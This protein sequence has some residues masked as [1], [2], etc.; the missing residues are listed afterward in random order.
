[1][2]IDS[3]SHRGDLT[4]RGHAASLKENH[5]GATHTHTHTHTYTHTRARRESRGS[6]GKGFAKFESSGG[7]IVA[8]RLPN[9][10]PQPIDSRLA[11]PNVCAAAERACVCVWGGGGIRG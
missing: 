4:A 9:A 8:A 11:R 7:G 5:V 1:M 3:L 2:R 10:R 6:F